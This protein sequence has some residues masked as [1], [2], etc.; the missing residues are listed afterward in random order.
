M[1]EIRP[2]EMT[3][4]H[5]KEIRAALGAHAKSDTSAGLADPMESAHGGVFCRVFEDGE[6]V[7][8]YVLRSIQHQSTVEAEIS[9]SYGRAG[10]DLVG[11]VL[12]LIEQQC[13]AFDAIRIETCRK[14]LIKKLTGAGYQVGGVILRKK[15]GAE[16]F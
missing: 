1:I 4:D 9:L 2:E 14:G 15:R 7:A 6:P 16:C 5:V 10:F 12:P 8:W 3:P 13:A 11:A